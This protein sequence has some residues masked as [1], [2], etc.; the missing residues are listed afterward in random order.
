[1]LNS[2]FSDTINL[3]DLDQSSG[4]AA[5]YI[6]AR[7]AV[8]PYRPQLHADDD[9]RSWI[10]RMFE[11]EARGLRVAERNNMVLGYMR[12]YGAALDDRH[13]R[14]GR[15]ENAPVRL[16]WTRLR[17]S[18]SNGWPCDIRGER[19]GAGHLRGTRLPA[20]GSTDGR[21]K[22]ALPDAQSVRARTR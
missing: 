11:T 14:P 3:T 17:A 2:R 20:F 16:C 10:A 6:A 7:R 1:L 4:I 21:N 22:E 8:M 13:I 5:I 9:I 12:L 19:P 18:A 15:Q